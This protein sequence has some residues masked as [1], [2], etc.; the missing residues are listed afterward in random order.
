MSMKFFADMEADDIDRV[1]DAGTVLH[2]KFHDY[3][4]HEG[5]EDTCF[6]VILKGSVKIIKAVGLGAKKKELFALRQGDCFGEM[7]LLLNDKRSAS[8]L[9]AEEAFLLRLDVADVA[10]LPP[11]TRSKFF[12]RMAQLLAE[13]LKTTTDSLVNP[14]F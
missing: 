2:A 13:R 8:V 4:F 3:I 11:E 12:R 7:S 14:S 9:A 6:Y 1:L 5:A 10:L